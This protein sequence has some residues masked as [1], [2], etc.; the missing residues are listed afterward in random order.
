ML[1]LTRV[2]ARSRLVPTS[3]DGLPP[4]ASLPSVLQT[5]AFW[6]DP[7]AYLDGCRRLYGSRFTIRP[8]G[9]PPLV[10]FS[11][12][13]DVRAIVGAPAD[14]LHP[15]AGGAVI[16]PLVGD[17]SFMLAEED[18]HLQ[19]RRRVQPAFR[20]E[21]V[22]GHREMIERTVEE[23]LTRW[24]SDRV[25]AAHPLLRALTLRVILRTIF[26]SEDE[27]LLELHR[28]LFSMFA[29]TDSLVLHEAPL[30]HLPGWR[31]LWRRFL[32]DRERVD[33]LLCELM[34]DRG[35]HQGADEGVLHLLLA[36]GPDRTPRRVRDDLMSIILAGHETTASQLSWALQ[37]LAY[38]PRAQ[39]RVACALE[40]G[41]EIL[42]A[43][44]VREVLRHRPVF[45]FAIPRVTAEPFQLDGTVY[46]PPIHL[47]ACIHLL[48]HD[49]EIFPEP[50]RFRPER[51]LD[52]ISSQQHACWL[53]WG[54]GHR[55][56]PGHRLA[57]MEM[58]IVLR[59]ILARWCILP[60]A[61]HMETARWRSVIV[62]PGGGCRIL[63]RK[64]SL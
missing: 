25:F 27:R 53:P 58:Q 40:R 50:H 28:G 20:R 56:C 45:L 29:V 7:H 32:A 12:P 3:H 54:G 5:F 59:A 26:G 61:S 10:F 49:T 31:G 16:A 1:W 9:M 11:G 34:S 14:V 62:T 4:G 55:R 24:P 51:F 33:R 2:C 30:R 6:R 17:G 15:G 19:G 13:E 38:Q 44:T 60:G 42:L 35:H 37:L 52:E 41:E 18:Q 48:H 63:L 43:A 47:V 23:E 57:M 21:A 64:R 22:S 36:D 8:V 46:R 39:H